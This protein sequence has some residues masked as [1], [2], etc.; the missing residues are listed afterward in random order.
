MVG[1]RMIWKQSNGKPAPDIAVAYAMVGA[2]QFGVPVGI[3]LA[4][5]ERESNFRMG[6]VSS[7]GAVGVCQF[8]PK[9]KK[10][11]YRYAGFEFDLES[12]ESIIGMAAIYSYYAKL[13]EK[14]YGFRGED[15]W[16]FALAAHRWG[17]N[18]TQAKTL[19]FDG[20]IKDVETA[21]AK[22]NLWYNA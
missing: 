19:V 5:V 2:D 17:Q 15:R 22:N 1:G 7:A 3:L 12:W 9:Y 18:S 21:M 10:D 8:K 4:T 14:R 16:R 6:L 20:R 13:G 11:Y